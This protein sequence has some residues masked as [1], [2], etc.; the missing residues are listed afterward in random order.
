MTI[1]RN[2]SFGRRTQRAG[3]NLD[4]VAFENVAIHDGAAQLAIPAVHDRRPRLIAGASAVVLDLRPHFPTGDRLTAASAGTGRHRRRGSGESQPM[5]ASRSGSG[6]GACCS[7][8][9]RV[10]VA[11]DGRRL[12]EV[13]EPRLF[14][15]GHA[16]PQPFLA[17]LEE[18]EWY[19]AR[20][21]VPYRPRRKRADARRQER[22]FPEPREASAG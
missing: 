1:E 17:P 20:R 9:T 3:V 13:D 16:S 22:L 12:Q 19:P 15:T 8:V 6:S 14:A 4:Q 5:N 11:A 18:A 2:P 7:S 21:L 10:A